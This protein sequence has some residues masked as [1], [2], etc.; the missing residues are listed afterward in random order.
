VETSH[1]HGSLS[2]S[3]FCRIPHLSSILI[4]ITRITGPFLERRTKL[5]KSI[6]LTWIIFRTV[7]HS[8]RSYL[9]DDPTLHDADTLTVM[10]S[11]NLQCDN[12]SSSN[13]IQ[14]PIREHKDI[15]LLSDVN[16]WVNIHKSTTFTFSR[17]PCLFYLCLA[18]Q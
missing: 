9:L 12:L 16:R 6:S 7:L 4:N 13:D 15:E 10:L 1:V 11:L 14:W 5:T 2:L 8:R 3:H 18:R 17:N